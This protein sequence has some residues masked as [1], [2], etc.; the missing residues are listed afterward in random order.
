MPLESKRQ[1]SI[2]VVVLVI[3]TFLTGV[4]ITTLLATHKLYSLAQSRVAYQ[5]Q[6]ALLEGLLR[7]G[8]AYCCDHRIDLFLSD[9]KDQKVS[10]SF[11][12]WP[13]AEVASKIGRY[14]GSIT[15]NAQKK[16][17][18]IEAH[19]S[20]DKLTRRG[21]CTVGLWDGK[22]IAKKDSKLRIS[23]WSVDA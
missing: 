21:S 19:L 13:C 16:I 18:T 22:S 1:G 9:K 12:P 8:A 14:Q 10:L 11:D 4:F 15:V 2:I 3:M 6:C 23:N 5:Q 20:N 7:A 17:A